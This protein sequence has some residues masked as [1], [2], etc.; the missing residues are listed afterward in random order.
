MSAVPGP[1]ALAIDCAAECARI[2][3]WMAGTLASRLHRRGLVVAMSGGIDSSV[4]AALAVR[5]VGAGKVFGL[6]LP[7]RD[8]SPESTVRGRQLAAHLG[9]A[10]EVFDIAPALEALGCYRI[11][12]EAIRRVLPGYGKGWRSK[13]VIAG[14]VE[15][16]INFHRLVA[17]APDGRSLE[18]RIPLREYLQIVAATNFKQRVRKTMD[19]FHA[20]RLHYAVVGT[21]NRLEYDQGF[22]VKVGDGAAD[23]KP[24]AHLYKTQVYALARWLGLP[25]EIC[26]AQPTTDTYTLP[27]GQDEFYFALPYAQMDLALWS[28]DHGVDAPSLAVALG[29]DDERANRIYRDIAAKR[30]AAR[31]LHAPAE[32]ID[33]V[34][35]ATDHE[36]GL[37]VADRC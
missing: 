22:F 17:E 26:A 12:D 14:G 15:G 5:A 8:S 13:V 7:E 31:Y 1:E 33:P 23:L 4:C 27:H 6:L 24:I 29:I 18:A 34:G 32:T 35:S 11:R 30:R 19:Y 2:A 21:P 20:D 37:S 10:H 25:A 3:R 9:I 36:A 28:I 16:G